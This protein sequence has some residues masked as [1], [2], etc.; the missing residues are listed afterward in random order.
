MG[1]AHKHACRKSG[2]AAT[3]VV[4]IILAIMAWLGTTPMPTWVSALLFVF[5][6]WNLVGYACRNCDHCGTCSCTPSGV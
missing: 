5:G 1:H 3:G 4:L 2:S 6:L